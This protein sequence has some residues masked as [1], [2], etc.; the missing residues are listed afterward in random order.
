M[1]ERSVDRAQVELIDAALQEALTLAG[2]GTL[3][4]WL[5]IYEV[6]PPDAADERSLDSISAGAD[7]EALQPWDESG[8]LFEALHKPEM[9]EKRE[10][11][12]D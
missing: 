6:V 7:G 4:R 10:G 12:E 8:F 3:T 2:A 5:V 9:W 1:A 11:V